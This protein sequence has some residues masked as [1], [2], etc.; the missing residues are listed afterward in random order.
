MSFSRM[1]MHSRPLSPSIPHLSYYV[2]VLILGAFWLSQHQQFHS[3]CVP[4]QNLCL[5][6]SCDAHV[7]A[8]AFL[9]STLFSGALQMP[10]W[11]RWYSRSTSLRSVL[12]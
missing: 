5:D 1:L 9:F 11:V 10:R 2:C 8:G 12:V 3:V 6:Q 4:E 7:P